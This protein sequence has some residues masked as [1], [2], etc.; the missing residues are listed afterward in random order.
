MADKTPIRAVFNDSNVATG[1]AEF[2]TGDTIGLT[3]GGL[4]ASLSIGTAGQVLKV[5]SGASALEFGNVE[6][7]V[8]IDGATDLTSAT[9]ATGDQILLSDSGTEGRVTLAQLDTLFSGT[10]K[11]LTN[12]SIDLGSNTLTGSLAE[13]NSA[14][15]SDS[16]VSLT[17]SETLTN[18]TLTSPTINNPIITGMAINAASFTFEGST[19]DSFET[20]LTTVD[21]TADRTITL[22]NATGTIVLADTT[23]TLTNKTIDADNNTLSNIEVDN[24][25]SGVL[26]TDLS[27]VAGTDTTLASAKAIKA[28]VDSQVTAQDLDFQADSGGALSID[29]DSESLTFTGG[30]GIDTSGSGNAVTFAIDSTVATLTGSQTLTNKTLTSPAINEIIFEGST[31]DSFETTL[32]V[33]DPTADRTITIPNVTGT[34]VT[35]GDTGS[36]TN[37]MLAGSIAAS[38]LAGSIGNSK[39]SNST[40]S[41]GGVQLSLGGTDATPAFNLSDA[42]DY[43]TSSLSGT[44]TNAQLAGSIA[45]DK[46]ANSS[47]NFGGVSLALGASDTTP[48]FDLS[49]ATNYPTSSLSGTITNAQLAGS[50]ANAKLANSTITVSDGGN[51]TA[52][53]LGGTITFSGTANEVTVTESSGTVTI[54][55]PD[56]V[57]IGNNLTV[58]GNLSVSGTTTTV[59]ST[60]VSIQNAFVFEGATADSFETTLTTV[61]PTADRTISLPNATGTIVLKDT[62]D[63]LTNKSISLANNTLTTTFAQLNTAVSNATLVSRTSTDTLTNKSIDSDNNTITN[64]ANA[65]IKSSAGIEFSKMEDLTASR[66]LASDSNGDVSATSV[67]STELGHLSGV[68][69]AIQTQLDTKTTAA[70][71]IAQAVAL[72]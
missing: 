30:T 18:K 12:K 10:S 47:I 66:A 16:F 70:F 56:N 38:K 9:L 23:D 49:D 69:S 14:L 27:S 44:I 50:I 39:L 43:P 40:V 5:N 17:G 67:T 15:Q 4:G 37:T 34:I 42:T 71:A 62:T 64:I 36:V 1:L 29:L 13:F 45:N 41:Y 65:D 28:Y 52:T 58:T 26:D 24:L 61:D 25:K 57:T 7:I 3:H 55:L 46:L 72:G 21:P 22:P 33:T 59:D 53:A 11:T 20:T 63:T 6:A 51:S 19:A 48:A 2:Q 54:S 35:T 8:N 68:T 31:A 60:T 32:A